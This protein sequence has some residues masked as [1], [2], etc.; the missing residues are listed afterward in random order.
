MLYEFCIL[1]GWVRGYCQYF[2]RDD[3]WK[4]KGNKIKEGS[5]IVV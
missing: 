3:K 4:G 5:L 1:K 2:N